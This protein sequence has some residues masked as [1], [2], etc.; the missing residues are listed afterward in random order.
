MC[1]IIDANKLGEFLKDPPTEDTRPIHEWLYPGR[2]RRGGV[3]VYSTVGKFRTEIPDAARRRLGELRQD[4]RAKFYNE[5]EMEQGRKA[6]TEEN[7]TSD[8][9]HV[10]GLAMASGA[11]VLYTGDRDLMDDFRDRKV[12]GGLR[13]KIY[14]GAKNRGLLRPNICENC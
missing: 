4:G 6:V 14:S 12:M 13:G 3:I 2:K 5:S 8:D 10:L 1:L 9:P 11:E 7:M